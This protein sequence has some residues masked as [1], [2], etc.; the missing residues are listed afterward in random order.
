MLYSRAWSQNRLVEAA[1]P[2]PANPSQLQGSGLRAY[3]AQDLGSASSFAGSG[4]SVT[5]LFSTNVP[6]N[7]WQV[8]PHTCIARQ[9]SNS[10]IRISGLPGKGPMILHTE[11]DT[12]LL[13][14]LE[15]GYPEISEIPEA[16]SIAI[17]ST[18]HELVQKSE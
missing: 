10:R 11:P 14:P 2:K 9:S 13:G 12:L 16:H 4:F 6:E 17:A 15:Q 1:D 18:L 7:S 3:G 5:V 8:H